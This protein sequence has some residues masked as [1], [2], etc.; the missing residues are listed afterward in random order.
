M[1]TYSKEFQQTLE[2]LW[3]LVFHIF[4]NRTCA[5]TP[6]RLLKILSVINDAYL[7]ISFIAGLAERSPALSN[8]DKKTTEKG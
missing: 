3:V 4:F 5:P 2:A 7:E 6:V 1:K 8:L